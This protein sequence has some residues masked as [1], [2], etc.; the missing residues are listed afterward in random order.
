MG[1]FFTQAQI[2]EI[3]Q[4]LATRSIRDTDFIDSDV[5]TGDEYIAIVQDRTNKKMPL[6]RFIDEIADKVIIVE[7]GGI[8]LHDETGDDAYGGMTQRAI[9]VELEKKVEPEDI[10]LYDETGDNTDGSMTQAAVTLALSDVSISEDKILS[11]LDTLT[12]QETEAL[13]DL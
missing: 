8:I 9:T 7:P 10:I 11:V 6:T 3:E 1:R 5:I 12:Q 2:D 13:L 4:R